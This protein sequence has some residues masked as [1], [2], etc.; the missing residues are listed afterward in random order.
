M[1]IVALFAA[2]SILALSVLVACR[3]KST[4]PTAIEVT[5]VDK[6]G[7]VANVVW[8]LNGEKM[9]PFDFYI[10]DKTLP[11]PGRTAMLELQGV[12]LGDTLELTCTMTNGTTSTST[13]VVKG[14][15]K[16]PV[17]LVIN[18]NGHVEQ[19]QVDL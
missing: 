19:K 16:K 6:E 5:V 9:S 10:G 14:D 12:R 18:P 11:T 15:S 7:L 3:K 8:T 1:K 13:L 2:L 17:Y 4:P